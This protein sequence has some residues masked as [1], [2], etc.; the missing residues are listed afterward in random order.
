MK[1]QKILAQF[2]VATLLMGQVSFVALAQDAPATNEQAAQDPV[3]EEQSPALPAEPPIVTPV[4]PPVV[5]VAP[6]PTPVAIPKPVDPVTG[7]GQ[8][9]GADSTKVGPSEPTGKKPDWVFNTITGRWE[10][11]KQ[12]T[13]TWDAKSGYWLSPLYYYDTRIGWYKIL[14][15]AEVNSPTRPSYLI[16]SPDAPR[17]V[18][19][20][21]G[22]LV[23]G[24]DKYKMALALG[25]INDPAI[26]NTGPDSNN[27]ALVHTTSNGWLD[28]TNLVGV[29]NRL[30]SSAESGDANVSGN[31]T[32]ENAITGAVSIVANILNLLSS[33]WSW[34]NGNLTFLLK[35]F[36][37][38]HVGDLLLQPAPTQGGG[39]SLGTSGGVAS[40]TN[41]GPNS[42]NNAA[43]ENDN[44][45]TV[46]SQNSGSIVN[47]VDL[48][49]HSGSANVGGNTIA[50]NAQTGD[51]TIEINIINLINSLISSDQS[52]FA[53]LNIFGDLN[54]DIL[55]P[56]GFLD[57]LVE[58]G[59]GGGGPTIASNTNT[60]PGS[61]N[62]ANSSNNTNT[63]LNLDN[64]SLVDNQISTRAQSGSANVSGNNSAGNAASGSSQTSQ[65]LF[66]L[67]NI[68]IAGDNAVLV[69]VNV[70]GK[71]MGKIM[72]IG[73]GGSSS[74]LLTG[75]ASVSNAN[76]GPGSTNVASQSTNTNTSIDASTDGRII[77][78]VNA[79]ASTGDANVTDNTL[80][81]SAST[82]N[83]R[84]ASNVANIFGSQFSLKKWFGI[85]VINV[86]G[87]WF[88]SVG[89]D[90][91]AGNPV[92]VAPT[93]P[94]AQLLTGGAQQTV[95]SA[96]G[97]NYFD[98]SNTQGSNVTP[99]INAVNGS[100][101]GLTQVLAATSSPSVQVAKA[102]ANGTMLLLIGA[103]VLMLLAGLM[104][105]VERKLRPRVTP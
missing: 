61:S 59:A 32:A 86:F 5:P 43:L 46:N 66:N 24:S 102:A 14:T 62:L 88:G 22:D 87:S 15:A 55:F 89:Q 74:A 100:G 2:L 79:D 27:T 85:L 30:Q 78:R 56:D 39:G 7:P 6:A 104:M 12:D 3:V 40:N 103:A 64:T 52:F 67:S 99:A 38:S 77:N 101:P 76:T 63:D 90:T 84:V 18:S 71:W 75:G 13:F 11:A 35:N 31:T 36:F 91:E 51:A 4:D 21:I 93:N 29:I 42:N 60:G 23:V 58:S 80:A 95:A 96:F 72:N 20:P 37:G 98:N 69:I 44:N 73:G 50:G 47:D 82:G 54:G 1:R 48:Q 33:A 10:E 68:N 57:G 49:A 94:L 45:L 70:M 53:M 26:S 92:V 16:T 17:V 8:E 97:G 65:S 105:G 25:L 81:G 34:S 41:T 83:A 9:T 19:S 28:F